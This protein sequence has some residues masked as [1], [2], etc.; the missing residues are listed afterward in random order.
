MNR[1]TR[2]G[3]VTASVVIV[4]VGGLAAASAAPPD[5]HPPNNAP[6]AAGPATQN[7]PLATAPSVSETAFVP[8]TPC[9][10]VDTRSNIGRIAA[11]TSVAFH[12]R[13][14]AGFE[15]QGGVSG[16]CGIP[17]TATGIAVSVSSVNIGGTGYFRAW[18]YGQTMPNASIA[19]YQSGPITTTGATLT[20]GTGAY[21]IQ[22]EAF[23]AG[24]ALV[25]DVTGYY[26]VPIDA[27]LSYNGGVLS[28]SPR[29]LSSVRTSPGNYTVTVDR[30]LTGCT[31]TATVHG[32]AYFASVY[33]SGTTLYAV[34]YG[35]VGGVPT[36][37]DLYWSVHVAC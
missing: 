36:P 22:V 9:R 4:V 8:I 13:G 20:L 2:L 7:V 5:V 10:I 33:E 28:G 19:H 24:S 37:Q 18:P 1:I 26:I 30:D 16:G 27:V 6:S 31:A 17:T 14:T 25:I 34:T 32:G 29:V 15:P 11:G 23:G 12:V 21:D 35:F 3:L